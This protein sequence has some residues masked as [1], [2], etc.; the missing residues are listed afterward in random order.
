MTTTELTRAEQPVRKKLFGLPIDGLLIVIVGALVAFGLMMVY[1]TTFDWSYQSYGDPSLVFFRQVRWLG[2]GVVAMSIA[3]YMPYR[4]WKRLS[5]FLMGGTVAALAAVLLFG[6]T[7]FNAQRS[8]FNGSVQP[9]ELAKLATILYLAVWLDSKSDRLHEMGYGIGPFGVIVGVVAGLILLQPDL[10]AAAT[11]VIVAA[12]MFFISG[13]D[14]LQ[15]GIV[16]VAGTVSALLV[17]QISATGRSRLADYIAGLQN[18]TQASWQVQ[19]AAIAFINGGVFGRGLGE[20]HQKFG[21]LPTPHT[22]SIF[23]IVGEELGLIGCVVLILLFVAL[24]WRGFKIASGARDQLGAM[25]ASGI[26]CWVLLEAIVNI[27]VM[28]GLLPFAGNALPFISYG[29]SN[30]VMSMTAMGV[31]LSVSRREHSDENISR[32]TR[33]NGPAWSW[34]QR[35]GD[36]MKPDAAPNFGR[37]N[38]RRSVPRSVGR[39]ESH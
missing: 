36:A 6:S 25:L 23:A 13:A 18:L 28:V 31:L 37:R 2:V 12:F 1:S 22:D 17:L 29:G 11:V 39:D 16:G 35:L 7:T 34:T 8:F 30:L 4:W 24:A 27:A 33:V 20:S 10:S 3:A 19:Q 15:M 21:F 32:R 9:S 38:G 5:V 14:I 26:M